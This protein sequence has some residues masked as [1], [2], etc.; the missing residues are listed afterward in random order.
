MKKTILISLLLVLCGT[1]LSAQAAKSQPRVKLWIPDV[2]VSPDAEIVRL[3]VFISN[4][5]DTIAGVEMNLQIENNPYISFILDDFNEEGLELAVDK[6][7]SAI[8]D[9]EFI[10]INGSETDMSTMRA[11]AM[12][13]WPD[14]TRTPPMYAQDSTLLMTLVCRLETLYPLTADVKVKV[15]LKSEHTGISDHMGNSIGVTTTIERECV[16]YVADSCISWKNKRI[17]SV[18][19]SVLQIRGCTVT[20][21]HPVEEK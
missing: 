20:I 3:P 2:T 16:K 14:A 5:K 13:D 18:D 6:E 17:G 9:W 4:P 12:A 11:V 8:K 7:G 21:S 15:N 10:D 19:P 1:M